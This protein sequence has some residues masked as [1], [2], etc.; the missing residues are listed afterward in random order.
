[1]CVALIRQRSYPGPFF[2]PV[3]R[4]HLYSLVQLKLAHFDNDLFKF[5]PD[6]HIL[7]SD[8]NQTKVG[9]PI[10]GS[11]TKKKSASLQIEI[12]DTKKIR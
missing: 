3:I 10:L 1:M 11:D 12:S 6:L 4:V 8:S 2:S 7:S 9:C 5:T